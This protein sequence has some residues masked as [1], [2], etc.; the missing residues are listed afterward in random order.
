[1]TVKEDNVL[2]WSDIPDV[3][4]HNSKGFITL[5]TWFR[6]TI[7]CLWNGPIV[8][9]GDAVMINQYYTLKKITQMRLLLLR[10]V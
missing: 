10:G 3:L 9:A 4:P 1:M 2:R 8:S 7:E 6:G 5:R